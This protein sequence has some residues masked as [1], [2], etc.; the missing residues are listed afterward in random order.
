MLLLRASGYVL[1]SSG[2]TDLR[3]AITTVI[4]GK[5]YM[6]QRI[7]DRRSERF[8]RDPSRLQAQPLT[9][10]QREVLQLLAEGHSMKQAAAELNITMRT[11]AF[12]KYRIMEENDL[13]NNS[14][15]VIFAI[16][17]QVLA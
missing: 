11:I 5:K 1:K 7:A 15:L 6:S 2:G 4:S 13:R 3:K 17:Q 12:H 14:D 10:R 16:K 8:I 9:P